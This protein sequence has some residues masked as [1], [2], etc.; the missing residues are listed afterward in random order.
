MSAT[1]SVALR[2]LLLQAYF[3]PD[4]FTGTGQL[5]AAV[6]GSVGLANASG[7][8]LDEPG[9][10]AYARAIAPL[11]SLTWALTGFGEAYNLVDLDFPPPN[12]GEDW[13]LL[14]GWALLDAPD[15]GMTLAVG[16]LIRPIYYTA[17]LPQLSLGPG[18]ITVAL[19]D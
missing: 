12:T 4:G 2:D 8:M 16:A 1:V 17:D 15:S 9:A 14:T 6:T 13:G 10:A 7:D 19:H 3:N 5:Y 18:A 11:D